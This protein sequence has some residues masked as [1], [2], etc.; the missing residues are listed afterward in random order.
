PGAGEE[1]A[2]WQRFQARYSRYL[3]WCLH[4]PWPVIGAA[5]LLS[6]AAIPFWGRLG[7]EF[8]PAS[9]TAGIYLQAFT[10]PGT[11]LEETERRIQELEA[12]L[13]GLPGLSNVTVQIGDPGA[14]DLLAV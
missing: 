14:T 2:R 8:L 3:R 9:R 11:P 1:D 12:G 5:V 10:P 7:L 13:A 4:R 6:V